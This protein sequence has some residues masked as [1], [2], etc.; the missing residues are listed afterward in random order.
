MMWP[1]VSD[2]MN[3]RRRC[4][5]KTGRLFT[6][7]VSDKEAQALLVPAWR[8]A[9]GMVQLEEQVGMSEVLLRSAL[10]VLLLSVVSLGV[11]RLQHARRHKKASMCWQQT[12]LQQGLQ[13]LV[14]V[15]LCQPWCLQ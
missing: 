15:Q 6:R 5:H 10:L 13:L 2:N 7:Q 4:L 12:A 8:R 1:S 9:V 14:R 11:A 3:H